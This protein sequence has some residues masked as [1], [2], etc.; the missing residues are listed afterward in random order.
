MGLSHESTHTQAVPQ[1]FRSILVVELFAPSHRL[2]FSRDWEMTVRDD[3]LIAVEIL[4]KL[5]L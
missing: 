2:P 3:R 4:P 5:F 1:F